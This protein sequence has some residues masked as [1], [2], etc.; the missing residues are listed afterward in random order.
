VHG[1]WEWTGAGRIGGYGHLNV[2]KRYVGAHR[3]AYELT[4]GPI[5]R[6]QVVCHR[7]D[8]PRCV[9]PDHLFLGTTRDNM[10]DCRDKGRLG[11]KRRLG[12]ANGATRVTPE[13]AERVREARAAGVSRPEL[14]KRF[15]ISVFTITQITSNKHWTS[16]PPQITS[17]DSNDEGTSLPS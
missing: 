6:G 17:P 14:A 12:P 1:C 7:C 13:I 15:G 3:F 5:P 8:N 9:R 16:A 11:E 10:R 4:H 2:G